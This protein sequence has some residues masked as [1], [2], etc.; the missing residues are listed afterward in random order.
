MNEC[1][2]EKISGLRLFQ[3]PRIDLPPAYI[4]QL[5]V[6]VLYMPGGIR[7]VKGGASIIDTIGDGGIKSIG[8]NIIALEVRTV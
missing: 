1:N 6:R 2:L 4:A 3:I 8:T 7:Y 5:K